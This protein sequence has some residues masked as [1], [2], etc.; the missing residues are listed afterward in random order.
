MKR[1]NSRGGGEIP[2]WADAA[3]RLLPRML[4]RKFLTWMIHDDA[5]VTDE[6]VAEFHD[7]FRRD[8]NRPAEMDRLRDFTV[9]DPDPVLAKVVAPTLVMWGRENPQLPYALAE[10]F[11]ERLTA[12]P[13]VEVMIV[14][15]AG[16]VLPLEEPMLSA[17]AAAAF[18][19]G[20]VVP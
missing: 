20:K 14:P 17:E 2:G 1:E 4:Y 15:G 9:D 3:V 19:A 8:G 7:N 16:H 10:G 12:T 5:L 18:M 6:L 11:R 13:Q